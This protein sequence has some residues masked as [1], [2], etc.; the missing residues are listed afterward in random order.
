MD[1]ANGAEFV[2]VVGGAVVDD[3]EIKLGISWRGNGPTI[4]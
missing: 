2:G 3:G 1:V 4:F